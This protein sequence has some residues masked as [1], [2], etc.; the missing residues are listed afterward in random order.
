VV[1]L[2][3]YWTV[4]Y[5]EE[6]GFTVTHTQLHTQ[7]PLP[8]ILSDDAHTEPNNDNLGFFFDLGLVSSF[9]YFF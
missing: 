7:A 4:V 5:T 6:T 8:W 2:Y 3:I 9:L 1:G